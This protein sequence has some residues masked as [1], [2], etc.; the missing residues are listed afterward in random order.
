VALVPFKANGSS[1][2]GIT[3]ITLLLLLVFFA[4]TIY[5]LV[6]A[7]ETLLQEHFPVSPLAGVVLVF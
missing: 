5:N 6:M 3:L 2:T 4:R 7:F 1:V